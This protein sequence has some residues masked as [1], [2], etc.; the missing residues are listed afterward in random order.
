VQQL[1]KEEKKK[2]RIQDKEEELWTNFHSMTPPRS[3]SR[4]FQEY[5]L[6]MPSQTRN[7]RSL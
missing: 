4:S 6:E 5:H 3:R 7:C 2:K 1:V